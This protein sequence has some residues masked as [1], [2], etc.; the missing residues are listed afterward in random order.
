MKFLDF[1]R[2]SSQNA[3][4]AAINLEYEKRYL[5][6][7]W[8][9]RALMPLAKNNQDVCST[10]CLKLLEKGG[11]K[12]LN[13]SFLD[14]TIGFGI[15]K[16]HIECFRSPSFARN[17]FFQK[18]CIGTFNGV[19]QS[20]F[21][22]PFVDTLEFCKGDFLDFKTFTQIFLVSGAFALRPNANLSR[23]IFFSLCPIWGYHLIYSEASTPRDV[24]TIA[25]Y[26]HD[27]EKGTYQ[28][29]SPTYQLTEYHTLTRGF[30]RALISLTYGFS[31]AYLYSYV[32]RIPVGYRSKSIWILDIGLT[33]AALMW[34]RLDRRLAF[35]SL[36]SALP[37]IKVGFTGGYRGSRG[38]GT[39][40]S[41]ASHLFTRDDG[42]PFAI[43]GFLIF[44]FSDFLIKRLDLQ[45]RRLKLRNSV[46]NRQQSGIEAPPAPQ[47]WLDFFYRKAGEAVKAKNLL[48][49]LSYGTVISI[50]FF[51]IKSMLSTK[52][53][54]P[55]EQGVSEMS[56][57]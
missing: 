14:L 28:Q 49:I 30:W 12:K 46:V 19:N 38:M 53:Q 54:S 20:D 24:R 22:S 31:S 55:N 11:I 26:N 43:G 7:E 21:A 42:I 10:L 51:S 40:F 56:P 2:W 29:Y 5:N 37:F 3:Y 44:S 35:C 48:N 36:I 9:T 6:A 50:G 25:S 27:L 17:S 8:T 57:K 52:A 39:L 16:G 45:E 13:Y 15:L 33:D 47:S 41:L 4:V 34:L 32:K 23:M 18:L 1:K